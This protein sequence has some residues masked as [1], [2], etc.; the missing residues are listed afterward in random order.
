M[1]NPFYSVDKLHTIYQMLEFL[2]QKIKNGLRYVN[3]QHVYEL[4]LRVDNPVMV[5]WKGKYQYLSEY[6]LTG[7]RQ[8]A[9]VCT[10][11][12][13]SDCIYRAGEYS[14][15]SVEEQVKQGFLTAAHGERIGIAGEYVLDKGQPLAVRNCNG[16]CIRVPHEVVGCGGEVYKI[17]M[18]DKV[19]NLL[20]TS[21]PGLGKT[22]ILRDLARILSENTKKNILIC[23]ERGE[24]SVGKL[25]ETCD[26]IKFL[27]KEIAFEAGIRAM[28]P[29]IILTDEITIHD[30][31]AVEKAVFAGVQVIA[32]AHYA[33]IAHIAEPFFTLFDYFVLLDEGEIGKIKATYNKRGEELT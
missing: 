21:S 19:G 7:N 11:E 13:L 4:R 12:D 32:T 5:S 29:D 28:R 2:P 14:V 23:D 31:K 17:C 1:Q 18:S 16:L 6:G 20:L 27:G 25:G 30:L 10:A 33:N 15:Y 3:L 26:V 9:L 8:K 22:T 24:I